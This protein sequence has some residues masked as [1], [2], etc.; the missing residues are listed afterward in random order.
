MKVPTI[1]LQRPRG[2]WL[3]LYIAGVVAIVAIVAGILLYANAKS[4]NDALLAKNVTL[5]SQNDST[6]SS[7]SKVT[8]ERDSLQAKADDVASREQAVT[9]A[10]AAVK[11]REDAVQATETHIQETTL[12]DGAVYTV[13]TTMQ[14]GTYQATSSSSRCYWEITSSGSNYG[15]IVSNDIGKTGTISVSVAGGQD[16]QSHDCGNWIKIG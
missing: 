16:F 2:V 5:I 15:D 7:L 12:K 14:A 4:D 9:A 1:R 3:A 6:R 10:E 11:A 13:G 8:S